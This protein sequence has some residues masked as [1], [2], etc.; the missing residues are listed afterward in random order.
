MTREESERVN[1]LEYRGVA[2][3]FRA[4][5]DELKISGYFIVFNDEAELWPGVYERVAPEALN[6]TLDN[7]IR[8][9]F[10]HDTATVLG[11]NKSSTLKLVK[12]DKG[13]YGE[14]LINEKD[15]D[16]M[17]VY[18]R[19]KRG[20]IDQ[21]SF[22]F[23]IRQE[24]YRYDEEKDSVHYTLEDIDLHEVSIVTFPAYPNTAVS[25]RAKDV[26]RIRQERLNRRKENLLRKIRGEAND[27][28]TT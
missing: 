11:R 27:P 9:L 4:A 8:C 12:D 18:E 22:G 2:S 28:T 6:S 25:A 17:N 21:C 26:E 23:N 7:D 19:V 14:V 10:N 1:K 24:S 16:A 20:D 13:L 15:T 3:D 5:D